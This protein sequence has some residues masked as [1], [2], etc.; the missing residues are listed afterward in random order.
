MN[1]RSVSALTVAIFAVFGLACASNSAYAHDFSGDESASFLALIESIRVE[2]M[3]VQ[4]NAVSNATLAEEH[5]EHAHHHLDERTIEEIAERN[6]RL[7]GDLPAALEALHDS[8]GNATEE[9]V[10]IMVQ[11]INDLLAETVTVRIDSEQRNNVTVW[12]LTLAAMA[13]GVNE[14]YRAAYGT[15]TD[16][17]GHGHDEEQTSMSGHGNMGDTAVDDHSEIVDFAQYQTSLALANRTLFLF[18]DQV[19]S[20]TPV[21]SVIALIDLEEGLEHLLVAVGGKETTADVEVILHTQ[22]HPNL[23]KAYGLKLDSHPGNESNIRK[24]VTLDGKTYE[25]TGKSAGANLT[26]IDI[27][28]SKSVKLTFEGSGEVELSL[29]VTMIEGINMVQT[30]D[31]HMLNYTANQTASAT[32]IAFVLDENMTSIEVMGAMVVPEFPLPLLVVLPAIVATIA[33]TRTRLIDRK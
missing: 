2:I 33:V 28:P 25:I 7:G 20:L 17:G 15:E 21:V 13:D 26:A 10:T 22:V 6:E 24:T 32:T 5:A 4:T 3:L 23:Q 31:G 30:T 29:P 12:A 27:D 18:N 19:K 1:A 11:G 16:G 8:V 9:D 14:H